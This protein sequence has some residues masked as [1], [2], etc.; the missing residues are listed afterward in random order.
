MISLL[1]LSHFAQAEATYVGAE[2][3]PSYNIQLFS[4]SIDSKRTF[5]LTE[6]SLP[7]RG[8]F[9]RISIHL[10]SSPLSYTPHYSNIHNEKKN[11]VGSIL[12]SDIISGVSL[13]DIR[14][15]VCLP[16]VLIEDEFSRT[17][18]GD[19]RFDA[20]YVISNPHISFVG[21]SVSGNATIPTATMDAPFS[22]SEVT[23]GATL[24]IERKLTEEM[25]LHGNLGY[26]KQA[27]A[28]FEN[29]YW[30]TN[31]NLGTGLSYLLA[32]DKNFQLGAVGEILARS[33]IGGIFDPK[34]TVIDYFL[35]SWVHIP[36]DDKSKPI[37]MRAGLGSSFTSTPGS[38]T[39]IYLDTT[40]VF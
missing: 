15:A 38:S 39:R 13:G 8:I 7:Y 30:G 31:I 5:L 21:I 12:Q 26:R 40:Y 11:L 32:K 6:T 2:D 25:L 34:R 1:L 36:L 24:S 27:E 17:G 4:T 20:K 22:D 35:G 10:S 18:L 14:L 19:I 37:N 23:H 29:F 16:V 33:H 3:L 28:E 9:S